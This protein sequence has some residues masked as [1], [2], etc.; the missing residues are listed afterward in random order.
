MPGL[1]ADEIAALLR[2]IGE[3]MAL[4]GGNPYRACAYSR[5]AE[6][7]A[8]TTVPIDQLIAENRLKEIPGIGDALA[9]AA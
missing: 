9:A 7:L 2:E 8:L 5:A 6:N 3:R 1:G 4:S